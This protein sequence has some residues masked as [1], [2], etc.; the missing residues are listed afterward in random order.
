[1]RVAMPE[2]P[3]GRIEELFAAALELSPLQRAAYLAEKESDQSLRAEVLSLLDAHE[4]G[5]GWTVSPTT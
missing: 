5:V 1:M 2:C 4:V 3:Q